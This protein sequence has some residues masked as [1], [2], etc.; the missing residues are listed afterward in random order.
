MRELAMSYIKQYGTQIEKLAENIDPW[1]WAM[2]SYRLAQNTTYPPM[3]KSNKISQAYSDDTF[4]TAKKRITLAGYRIA[5]LVVSI[6]EKAT[7]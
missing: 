7:Q 1:V 6:F 4:E 5:N 3:F 2:E